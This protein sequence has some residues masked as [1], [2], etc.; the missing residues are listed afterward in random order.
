M[1]RRPLHFLGLLVLLYGAACSTPAPDPDLDGDGVRSS[2][3]C[4]DGDASVYPGAE[5]VCADG[6]D[7]DCNG[8]DNEDCL[9]AS[10]DWDHDGF[11]SYAD[12]G[13]DCNDQRGDIH[14]GAEEIPYDGID[15]DC[16]G[17]DL[18]D[19]DGDGDPGV[20]AGG[21]DCDDA[22]PGVSSL[23]VEVPYDGTDQ[24][25]DGADLVD[26]DGDG[27]V[28][29]EAGGDDCDDR[30]E[31]VFEGAPEFQ[32]DGVD[33][34][35]DGLDNPDEDGDG[36]AVPDDCDDGSAAIHP[37]AGE[38]SCNLV[39]EDCDGWISDRDCDGADA[40]PRGGDCDDSDPLLG[41]GSEEVACNGVDEDCD[42]RLADQDCDGEDAEVWGGL[43]CDDLDP[44]VRPFA[45]EFVNGI[46]DNCNGEVDERQMAEDAR[47]ALDGDE[48]AQAGR[49]IATGDFNGDGVDDLAV[50]AP[51]WTG[52][53][54][55]A[56]GAV[57]VVFGAPEGLSDGRLSETGMVVQGAGDGD[58]CG[59]AL[60]AHDV[61]GDG[62]DDLIVGCPG[63]AG[64]KGSIYVVPGGPGVPLVFIDTVAVASIEG[65][66]P[67]D[68]FGSVLA[69]AGDVD[70]DGR[71]DYLVGAPDAMVEMTQAVGSAYLFLGRGFVEAGSYQDADFVRAG[72]CPECRAGEY[73]AG[74]GDLDRDGYDDFAVGAPG[75]SNKEG[76][77][78]IMFGGPFHQGGWEPSTIVRVTSGLCGSS[79]SLG[80]V[81]HAGDLNQD[82]EDDLVVAAPTLSDGLG[83][84]F[85][86]FGPISRNQSKIEM[87]SDADTYIVGEVEGGGF[88][89][90]MFTGD[91]DGDLR[92]DLLVGAPA[93]N[94]NQGA[95]YLLSP[96]NRWGSTVLATSALA[97]W[98]GSTPGQML[99]KAV[100]IADLDG[101]GWLDLN[102]GAPGDDSPGPSAG[103]VY[104]FVW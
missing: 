104:A 85:I 52:S 78:E 59:T 93:S 55:E 56:S 46:D 17:E 6:I 72:I 75:T 36:Y 70:G 73:V 62:I 9:E 57:F 11:L 87:A 61:G 90:V 27:H 86:K 92:R 60:I 4:D 1:Q 94:D 23:T 54:G 18:D 8:Q 13:D 15:Q 65:A 76:R 51:D 32:D 7:Q 44:L 33:S 21:G 88:G 5:D 12:G 25:C 66:V 45:P 3:D 49:A 26:V 31:D 96:E 16:D 77:I 34:D 64:G 98:Q 100:V 91:F 50:G 81:V 99:G 79:G 82:G 39:D 10:R 47:V 83:A 101:D 42:G 103:A 19:L 2:F 43:D 29:V 53:N 80:P 28:A 58:R 102:A 68:G 14:P 71:T 69:L 30:S 24:D 67:G 37:G 35:C 20:A 95:I 38:V 48:G 74:V 97:F 89:T 40:Q 84:V 63:A 41:P 22:D